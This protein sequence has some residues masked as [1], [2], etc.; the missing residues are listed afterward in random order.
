M[1]IR[2][3]EAKIRSF[4]E[5]VKDD[6]SFEHSRRLSE[7]GQLPLEM[8]QALLIHPDILRTFMSFTPSIYPG[9]QIERVLKEKMIIKASQ[10]NDC[11]FCVDSHCDFIQDFGV[12]KG[13]ELAPTS[14]RERVALEYTE[15]VTKNANMV[16]EDLFARLKAVFTDEEIVELTFA[17]GWINMLNRFN[18]AL[19]I[20]YHG[21]YGR[22]KAEAEVGSKAT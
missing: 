7:R 8:I 22:L 3:D 4:F 2:V 21:E 12:R 18:N 13:Q 17:I 10:L 16:S 11:Q 15:V 5:E 14:E 6:P 19:Q 20:R 9:G 1:R